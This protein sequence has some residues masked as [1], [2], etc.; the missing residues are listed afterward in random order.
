M[1]LQ[2]L[3][4]GSNDDNGPSEQEALLQKPTQQPTINSSSKNIVVKPFEKM[5]LK[6]KEEMQ[7]MIPEGK[8]KQNTM[9]LY[10]TEYTNKSG[11]DQTFTFKT[12]RRMQT[13]AS[14]NVQK[15]C[16]IGSEVQLGLKLPK[17]VDISGKLSQELQF[18]KSRSHTVGK[19]EVSRIFI[20][21]NNICTIIKIYVS[22]YMLSTF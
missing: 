1:E 15:S 12:E 18:T 11:K 14:V 9:S 20:V 13:S 19:E 4:S 10:R 3:P 8:P 21:T 7:K 22:A 2:P 6:E 5:S 17:Q 16:K